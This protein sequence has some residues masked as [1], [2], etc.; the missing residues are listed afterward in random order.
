M[1][2]QLILA[3]ARCVEN[4]FVILDGNRQFPLNATSLI[5]SVR[6][7]PL[8]AF[9]FILHSAW[10]SIFDSCRYEERDISSPFFLLRHILS[11]A[12]CSNSIVIHT[13]CAF[14]PCCVLLHSDTVS[15][16]SVGSWKATDIVLEAIR[17]LTSKCDATLQS[18]SEAEGEQL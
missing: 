7:V 3:R 6:V 12:I 16:E 9:F 15:V 4:V 11:T 17:I 8:P 2:L 5:L 18:L 1:W 13:H 14:Y 10:R